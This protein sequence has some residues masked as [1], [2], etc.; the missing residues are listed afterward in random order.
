[1]EA[2]FKDFFAFSFDRPECHC[3]ICRTEITWVYETPVSTSVS[4]A[5]TSKILKQNLSPIPFVQSSSL[6]RILS[7][8]MSREK[9]V[10]S[11]QPDQIHSIYIRYDNFR[12][13]HNQSVLYVSEFHITTVTK[14]ILFNY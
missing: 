11:G 3:K 6:K 2:F 5:E 7:Q 13:R 12:Y 10:Y 1:M 4:H 9:G 8:R 14:V